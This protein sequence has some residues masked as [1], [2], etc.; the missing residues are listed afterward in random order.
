MTLAATLFKE[1]IDKLKVAVLVAYA[2]GPSDE[3]L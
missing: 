1:S 2:E 3:H